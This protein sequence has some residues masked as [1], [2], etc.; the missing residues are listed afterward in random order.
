MKHQTR[1]RAGR[2]TSRYDLRTLTSIVAAV[3]RAADAE[4]PHLIRQADYDAARTL[5]GY[6]DA[7]SGGQT[8]QRFQLE[9]RELLRFALDDHDHDRAVAYLEAEPED[10]LLD[11]MDVRA[12]LRTAALR[13]GKRTLTS[14]EYRRDREQMLAEASLKRHPVELYVPSEHQI[15]R[16]AGSWNAALRIAGLPQRSDPPKAR[17]VPV[18]D[19]IEIALEATG[20]LPMRNDLEAF[21]AA[22]SFSLAR[23]TQTYPD[24]LAELRE[25]RADWGKWTPSTWAPREARPDW[26]ARVTLPRNLTLVERRRRAWA[27]EECVDAIRRLLEELGSERLSQRVYQQRA[28]GRRDLPPMFSIQRHGRFTELVNEARHAKRRR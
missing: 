24:S 26:G 10:D 11:R 21:A 23:A 9:W 14:A 2:F 22:N 4:N 12:A 7:P 6:P 27:R 1:G 20:C 17:G 25:R 15:L 19:A 8:A 28:I 5:A 3:A 16:I 13:L 18:V